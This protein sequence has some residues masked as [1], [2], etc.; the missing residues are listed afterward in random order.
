VLGRRTSR[1]IRL[2]LA[3]SVLAFLPAGLAVASFDGDLVLAVSWQPGFCETRPQRPE[4]RSQTSARF[5]AEHFTLHGLWPQPRGNTYCGLSEVEQDEMRDRRW[6]R[7]PAVPLSE[8][9]RRALDRAMPGTQS[10]LQRHQWMKH[11]TCYAA[12]PET[13]F[14]HALMLLGELNGSEVRD[15]FVESIGERIAAEEVRRR[16]DAAFG[17]AAGER[18]VVRCRDDGGRRL[19]TEL[20]IHLRGPLDDA[21]SLGERMAAAGARGASC[22]GGIVDPVGLQ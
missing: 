2:L 18:V 20:Q 11:G 22:R 21:S 12:E 14:R 3:C 5:D 10:N 13:Y 8:E 7:L 1:P 6:S 17:L 9:T 19:I 15:F 4:C 16:F